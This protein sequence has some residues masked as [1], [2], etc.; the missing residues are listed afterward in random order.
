MG[1][2]TDLW[3]PCLSMAVSELETRNPTAQL[4]LGTKSH[5]LSVN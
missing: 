3:G 1:Q 2:G 4:E 5:G